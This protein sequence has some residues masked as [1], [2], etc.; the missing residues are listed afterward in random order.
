MAFDWKDNALE[1]ATSSD[2]T[3]HAQS[4]KSITKANTIANSHISPDIPPNPSSNSNSQQNSEA[5]PQ[6]RVNYAGANIHADTQNSDP[7]SNE[8]SGIKPKKHV[9]Y[10]DAQDYPSPHTHYPPTPPMMMRATS[11]PAHMHA[12][13]HFTHP[14]RAASELHLPMRHPAHPDYYQQYYYQNGMAFLS[15]SPPFFLF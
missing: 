13:T 9:N 1:I 12:R 11:V 3:A 5:K 15:P 7:N 6:K 14:V 8:N 4:T 2:P 10:T